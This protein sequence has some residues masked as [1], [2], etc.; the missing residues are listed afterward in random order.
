[1]KR[2][3]ENVDEILDRYLPS[4]AKSEIEVDGDRVWSRLRSRA[5][6]GPARRRASAP[7]AT[8]FRGRRTLGVLAAAAVLLAAFI[9]MVSFQRKTEASATV[10][11]AD[12]LV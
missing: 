9:G 1:M 11:S 8:S 2:D 7:V 10:E 12:G 4:A 5:E 6:E 3:D